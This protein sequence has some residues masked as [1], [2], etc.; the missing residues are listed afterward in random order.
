MTSFDDQL[1][2][3]RAYYNRAVPPATGY[4]ED[5]VY[6][7]PFTQVYVQQVGTASTASAT[8]VVA[9]ANTA[10]GVTGTLTA[11]GPLVS[12]GV[13]TF[14]VARAARLTSTT[15]TSTCVIT[16]SGTD[17]YGAPLT[18]SINGPT[19]NTFGN[20]GSYV[21]TPS[22]FKTINTAS[23]VG[24]ST[25]GFAVGNSDSYGV[26][27]RIANAGKVIAITVDG[28]PAMG[29]QLLQPVVTAGL[30]TTATPGATTADVR[31]M[32]TLPTS[33]LANDSKYITFA[34]VTPNVGVAAGADTK[35]NSYGQTPYS[36]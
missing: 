32:I 15:N 35:D 24:V 1:K 9:Y 29:T 26:D 27:Y 2:S 33:N 20:V 36:A 8:A 31:G 22:A 28:V 10:T 21:D 4:A 34:Y 25:A 3:G 7:L 18:V 13:A 11:S 16:L 12:G 14:D 19:G 6:G 30:A 17:K 23:M 5:E